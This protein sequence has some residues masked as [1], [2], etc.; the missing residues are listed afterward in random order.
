MSAFIFGVVA[1]VIL[2][3]AEYPARERDSFP[4]R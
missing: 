2:R 1:F 4:I 3:A